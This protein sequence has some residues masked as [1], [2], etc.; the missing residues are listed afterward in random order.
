[1]RSS[2]MSSSNPRIN[3]FNRTGATRLLALVGLALLFVHA[4]GCAAANRVAAPQLPP[5]EVEAAA[6][7]PVLQTNHFQR[8]RAALGEDAIREILAAP[9]F[10]ES[11][12]RIGVVRVSDSY[13]RSGE[14]PV[15]KITDTLE[16]ALRDTGLFELSTEMSTDWPAD[17]GTA[18]LRELAARYRCDYLLLYRHRFAT[19]TYA[20]HYAW[21]YLT[22]VGIFAA[23]ARTVE[24]AGVL[25]ATLFDVKTGTLLFTAYERVHDDAHADAFSTD[26]A[27]SEMQ[28]RLV[29]EAA[30]GLADRVVTH[31]RRLA[32]APGGPN[33]PPLQTARGTD[34]G[35]RSDEAL[36]R[37]VTEAQ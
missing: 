18:G 22:V 9:V 37:G 5:L 28:A 2:N 21:L 8:D 20:N 6:A 35:L 32:A 24:T 34:V 16:Q 1:M 36:E 15:E 25:E 14:V 13:E 23:P 3:R 27:E 30:K 33:G 10:L 19:E 7:P 26:Q 17:R 4:A 12:S 11:E 29:D 31:T